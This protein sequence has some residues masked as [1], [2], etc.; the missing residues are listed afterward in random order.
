MNTLD[1]FQSGINYDKSIFFYKWCSDIVISSDS[2]DSRLSVIFARRIW[3]GWKLV[4]WRYSFSI[5]PFLRIIIFKWSFL[6]FQ[7]VLL[8]PLDAFL[9]FLIEIFCPKRSHTSYWNVWSEMYDLKYMIW[10]IWSNILYALDD[11]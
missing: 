9:P 11:F 1:H 10:N 2:S 8:F 4:S 7:K 3:D 6:F 5:Q